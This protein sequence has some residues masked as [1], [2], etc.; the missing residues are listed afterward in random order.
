MPY[1]GRRRYRRNY[2]N[3][4]RNYRRYRRNNRRYKNSR[5]R[6][7]SRSNKLLTGVP[8]RTRVKLAYTTFLNITGSPS[9]EWIFRG[10]GPSDPDSTGTGG[11]PTGYDQ[12]VQFY[13]R[14][15][16]YA[17]TIIVEAINQGSLSAAT[18]LVTVVP[19]LNLTTTTYDVVTTLPYNKSKMIG[20][21]TGPGRIYIKNYMSTK[22]MYGQRVSEDDAFSSL[23]TTTPSRQWY[24]KVQ[25]DAFD[26]TSNIA[27]DVKVTV[28]YYI[29]WFDRVQLA[30]S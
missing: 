21:Y 11:A 3:R 20:P 23:A 10:N 9:H 22:K 18:G 8:D 4:R 2:R 5:N 24:W 28:I 12:W 29:E 7:T 6:I 27:L 16:T 19:L 1:Y 30:A 26:P 15:R 14:N 25:C 13:S 17:S